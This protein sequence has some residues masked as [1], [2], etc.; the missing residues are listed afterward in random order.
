MQSWNMIY[1]E[2]SLACNQANN[3]TITSTRI[4]ALYAGVGLQIYA[5][6]SQVLS[7]IFIPRFSK[8]RGQ[9]AWWLMISISTQLVHIACSATYSYDSAYCVSEILMYTAALKQGNAAWKYSKRAVPY[10]IRPKNKM[11]EIGLSKQSLKQKIGRHC[12]RHEVKKQ[13]SASALTPS[14][15][16][17]SVSSQPQGQVHICQFSKRNTKQIKIL[18]SCFT[19]LRCGLDAPYKK[20]YSVILAGGSSGRQTNVFS[21]ISNRRLYFS[22]VKGQ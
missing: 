2:Y 21:G 5:T 3:E 15:R 8:S 10:A 16:W 9:K 22:E 20:P 19:T 12:D 1:K 13:A 7:D 11:R 6:V 17:R 4:I 18:Q 14:G